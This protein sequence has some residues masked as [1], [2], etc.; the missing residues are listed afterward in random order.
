L[1]ILLL[2]LEWTSEW[3]GLYLDRPLVKS[4]EMTTSFFLKFD[5]KCLT[6]I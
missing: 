3:L 5:L 2:L 1:L 6:L 4:P